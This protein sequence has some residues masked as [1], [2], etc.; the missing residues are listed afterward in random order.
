MLEQNHNM[1]IDKIIDIIVERSE[2]CMATPFQERTHY[3][4]PKVIL[5]QVAGTLDIDLT[6]MSTSDL[7]LYRMANLWNDSQEGGYLVRHGS[8]FVRDFGRP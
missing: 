4:I 3:V 6:N 5:L 1:D 8:Q 2:L 7:I